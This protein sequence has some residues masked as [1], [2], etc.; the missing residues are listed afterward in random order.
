MEAAGFAATALRWVTSERLVVVKVVSD[1]GVEAPRGLDAGELAALVAASTG[2]AMAHM[3]AVARVV[4]QRTGEARSR[5]LDACRERFRFTVTEGRR[6][7]RLAN[8]A[9]VL[10]L[11][12]REIARLEAASAGELMGLL[13]ERLDA[14]AG[15]RR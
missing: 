6:L 13:E 11:P 3:E 1:H 10:G 8:R 2:A 7:E 9:A 15:V 14:V 5:Y 4:R 12:V